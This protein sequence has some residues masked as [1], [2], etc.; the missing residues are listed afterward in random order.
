MLLQYYQERWADYFKEI[1]KV[2]QEALLKTDVLII[3]IGSTSVPGLAAKPVIDIDVVYG[4]NVEFEEVKNE[5]EKI[6]YYHN[7]NQGIKERE[8]FKRCKLTKKHRILDSISHHLYVCPIHSEEFNQ[9][10]LFRNFLIK[11][12]RER[13]QYQEIKI[14]IAEDAKQDGKKYARLKDVEARDFILSIIERAKKKK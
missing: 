4:L 10:L 12:K 6:G 14:Q 2:I 8:V 7:G 11:N 3:H 5:L 13:Q 1:R 9:H